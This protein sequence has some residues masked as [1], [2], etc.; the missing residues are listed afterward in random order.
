MIGWTVCPKCKKIDKTSFGHIG[1]EQYFKTRKA[2]YSCD[3]CNIAYSEQGKI[4]EKLKT[5]INK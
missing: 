2:L 3:R 4:L 1:W 5:K